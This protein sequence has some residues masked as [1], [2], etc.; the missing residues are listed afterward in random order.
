VQDVLVE[1]G[2]GGGRDDGQQ[3]DLEDVSRDSRAVRQEMAIPGRGV[4][5]L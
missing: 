4:S 2:R 1:G 5:Y 3:V